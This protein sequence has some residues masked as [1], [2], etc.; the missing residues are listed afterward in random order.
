MPSKMKINGRT[1]Y[2]KGRHERPR[3][4]GAE[5]NFDRNGDP[6][7]CTRALQPEQVDLKLRAGIPYKCPDEEIEYRVINRCNPQERWA[8]TEFWQQHLRVSHKGLIRLVKRGWFDAA[9]EEGSKVR[10]YRCRDERKM[11]ESWD[12]RK[13]RMDQKKADMIKREKERLAKKSKGYGY[14]LAGAKT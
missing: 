12:W 14:L 7:D 1:Y 9:I 11:K 3:K 4:P 13:L 5:L 6:I 2:G 10:R 8:S